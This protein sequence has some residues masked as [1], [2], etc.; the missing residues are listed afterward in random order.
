MCPCPAHFA[1]NVRCSHESITSISSFDRLPPKGGSH[2][3]GNCCIFGNCA[4]RCRLTLNNA[5]GA[6]GGARQWQQALWLLGLAHPLGVEESR[7][8][9]PM[10]APPFGANANCTCMR[11][12]IRVVQ[13]MSPCG[14]HELAPPFEEG[15]FVLNTKTKH[16]WRTSC[17]EDAVS[18]YSPLS[19]KN[20]QLCGPLS[21][22]Q[23]PTDLVKLANQRGMFVSSLTP[24][25]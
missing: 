21:P 3:F 23:G 16:G 19:P 13:S 24:W 1:R 5:C 12:T 7:Q 6:F 2:V 17:L 18:C 4:L 10:S 20:L 8:R 15:C 14:Q 9:G 11:H 22:S 25:I